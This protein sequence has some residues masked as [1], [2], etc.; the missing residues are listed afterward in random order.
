MHFFRI[1]FAVLLFSVVITLALSSIFAFVEVITG[2]FLE[3]EKKKKHYMR[4]LIALLILV[5]S[6]TLIFST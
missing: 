4:I 3:L 5:F 2:A 1:G 6:G